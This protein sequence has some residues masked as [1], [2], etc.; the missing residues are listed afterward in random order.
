MKANNMAKIYANVLSTLAKKYKLTIVGG[1]IILPNPKVENNKII[2]QNGNLYN[3]SFLFHPD[4]SIDPQIV[5]KVFLT[6]KEQNFLSAGKIE[7]LP[8]FE[9]SAGRLGIVICT[10]S[11]YNGVYQYLQNKGCK[12]IAVPAFMTPAGLMNTKWKTYDSFQKPKD[13]N[14]SD[15]NN[16]T[17]KQAWER[18][19]MA[20]KFRNYNF[21][22]GVNVFIRGKLWGNYYRMVYPIPL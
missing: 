19:A 18:Y 2:P 17:E 5:V 15:I 22:A 9:T 4:G 20:G 6:K 3:V 8:V 1:S 7:N 21:H 16:I 13:V 12:L 10:D 11:W 14:T